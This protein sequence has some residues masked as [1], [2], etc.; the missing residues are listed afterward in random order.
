VGGTTPEV[1]LDHPHPVQVGGDDVAGFY[2]RPDANILEAYS[3]GGLTS[4]A[5]TRALWLLVL[6]FALANAAGFMLAG[7]GRLRIPRTLMRLLSLAIT[8]LAVLW[9]GGL[10]LDLVAYQCGGQEVCVSGQ[11][12]M[13][14][15]GHPFF[16][17]QPARR[18]A[19]ALAIPVLVI[20]GLRRAASFGRGR[21]EEAF[22]M[23]NVEAADPP[24]SAD[25]AVEA[26]LG[27]HTFWHSAAFGDG[28]ARLH[29]GAALAAL[30]AATAYACGRLRATA[31]LPTGLDSTLMWTA[32]IIGAAAAVGTASWWRLRWLPRLVGA[33]AWLLV[34]AVAAANLIRDVS[35][36]TGGDY[37]HGYSR[38]A[39]LTGL[40]AL[41]L[42]VLLLVSLAAG[43]S[44]LLLAPVSTMSLAVFS[45]VSLLAGS[46]VRVAALLGD[47]RPLPGASQIVY[48]DAYDWYALVALAV[49]SVAVVT[50]T[51]VYARMRR[52]SRRE[53]FITEI[54]RRY[55]DAPVDEER[56]EWLIRIAGA[57]RLSALVD[58]SH[59]FLNW[60]GALV[61]LG[62]LGF[63]GVR[64]A[65]TG[66]ALGTLGG[67]GGP[68]RS[69]LPL[70]TW[71]E[72]L[73][74]LAGLALLYRSFRYPGTRRRVGVIWDVITF[75]PRWYH[76][77]APPPYAARAIPE[78]GVR[79]QRLVDE[80]S[81]VLVSAHSQGAVI[82]AST[83]ARL[84]GNVRRRL[85]LLTHGN[86]LA[87][88]YEKFFP[89]YFDGGFLGRLEQRVG[90]R[91]RNLFRRTDPIG[92]PVD[93]PPV[94]QSIL[95]PESDRHH[96]G[97]P[98][99][100]VRGHAFYATGPFPTSGDAYAA[101]VAE[102]WE[103]LDGEGADRV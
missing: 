46:H 32:I 81:E 50:A 79:L 95:D 98:L 33:A 24:D 100:P 12:W 38:A 62:A 5:G 76:P 102:L 30:A 75:W 80:G 19:L 85:A 69:L 55:G 28:L 3:W 34:A 56:R 64:V 4:R 77:L 83:I 48:S 92:G 37:L 60:L 26:G 54:N 2:R 29:S 23:E 78:L 25:L 31:G 53:E 17:G 101:A 9:I 86:P 42:A 22:T 67:V 68:L 52:D 20:A 94:D 35:L 6:P 36:A 14:P 39:L 63:Y 45:L 8:L 74:P 57:E 59:L 7:K 89:A 65:S 16:A 41:V 21:Y 1:L 91:W 71:L 13:A 11:W 40:A 84:P 93:L 90:G 103:R 15:F 82:A 44:P 10:A 49:I 66:S 97:D 70:A 43:R 88:L 61:V 73:L 47:R 51:T 27:H 87:R 18:V 58:R 99:P 72:S 96:P